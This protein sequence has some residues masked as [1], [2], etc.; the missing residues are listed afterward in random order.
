MSFFTTVLETIPHF[1]LT[2]SAPRQK[3][4]GITDINEQI[5][6][7]LL[8]AYCYAHIQ[9]PTAVTIADEIISRSSCHERAKG[10]ALCAK[11]MSLY[12]MGYLEK[13]RATAREALSV[14]EYL[15]DEAGKSEA[16]F[17]LSTMIPMGDIGDDIKENERYLH[18][19]Q[20]GFT[21]LDNAT[22]LCL[23]RIH[24]NT[25]L[26]PPG[27][28]DEAIHDCEKMLGEPAMCR[29]E[30]LR[31][32][33]YNRLAFANYIRQDM[34]AYKNAMK[35]WQKLAESTGNFYDYTL[36]RT[37]LV[38][39]H[40]LERLDESIM[41]ECLES[42]KCCEQLGSFYGYASVGIIMGNICMDQLQYRDALHYFQKANASALEV[43][44]MHLHHISLIGAAISLLKD[45]QADKARETFEEVLRSSAIHQDK[46]NQIAALRHLAELALAND[47]FDRAFA[48][49]KKLFEIADAAGLQTTGHSKY[50]LTISK[51]SPEALRIAGI[52][53]EERS[54]LQFHYLQKQLSH[55]KA[56]ASKREE[57]TAYRY[58]SDY[59]EA[60]G[61]MKEALQYHKRYLSLYEEVMHEEN[62]QSI[63][64]LRMQYETEKKDT[65]IILLKKEKHE[66]LLLERLRLSRDLH[67]DIGSTL[68]SLNFYSEIATGKLKRQQQE[69]VL[70]ILSKIGTASRLM[71]ERISDLVWSINPGNDSL[72][73]TADRLKSLAATLFQYMNISYLFDSKG[74]DESVSL[75]IEQRKN[76][77]LIYKEALNNII[78]Y[79]ACKTVTI[80]LYLY[81]ERLTLSIKDDGTGFDMQQPVNSDRT[82]GNG[83]KNMKA[84]AQQISGELAIHSAK[85]KGTEIMLSFVV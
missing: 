76:L 20:E 42:V 57:A 29:Q 2:L 49:F 71:T 13:A 8:Q 31:C 81:K 43:E 16:F 41:Q 68:S 32:M 38:E 66:A 22:G 5:Y 34:H 26:R 23:T 55:A 14:F 60:A 46:I 77:I 3:P 12:R 30:H 40:R 85:G 69:D 18:L 44:D 33:I 48:G 51:A 54:T 59:Y 61:L 62:D 82:G 74:I 25:F 70:D 80:G 50:A 27:R 17:H 64:Q 9:L 67:D 36:T 63:A 24:G 75:T 39:C 52:K 65:E 15:Q 10:Y 1:G 4:N 11:A 53:E 7:L 47:E 56:Q 21:R 84:R 6:G 45:E 78:K 28:F 72:Q 73:H 79:A 19:A 83:L 35:T 37:M 58:L